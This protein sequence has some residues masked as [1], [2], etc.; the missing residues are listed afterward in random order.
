MKKNKKIISLLLVLVLMFGA[1]DFTSVTAEV[2]TVQQA[3]DNE[4]EYNNHYDE[5]LVLPDR[6]LS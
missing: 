6:V 5:N 1:L 3:V 4:T 2:P